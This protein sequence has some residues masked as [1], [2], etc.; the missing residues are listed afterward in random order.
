MSGRWKCC[1]GPCARPGT[2][3]ANTSVDT[4]ARA[5]AAIRAQVS[6]TVPAVSGRAA[7]AQLASQQRHR[8]AS[9]P[10]FPEE[11][12]EVGAAA[13]VGAVIGAVSGAL[14]VLFQP[15]AIGD[16]ER[17]QRRIQET[18]SKVLAPWLT[19]SA[20]ASV[21]SADPDATHS[22]AM[23]AAPRAEESRGSEPA[24]RTDIPV[25]R[26][27]AAVLRRS[28][29]P[30]HQIPTGPCVSVEAHAEADP[31]PDPAPTYAC[32]NW[33]DRRLCD[34][35]NCCQPQA[36]HH[37]HDHDEQHD[38]ARTRR[39]L[40]RAIREPISGSDHIR[41]RH[42]QTECP[43]AMWPVDARKISD[44][45]FDPQLI[46]FA[47]AAARTNSVPSRVAKVMIRRCRCPVRARRR[48]VRSDP[49]AGRP[50]G[51]S[52]A[53]SADGWPWS[54]RP[55]AASVTKIATP[56]QHHHHQGDEQLAIDQ[57]DRAARTPPRSRR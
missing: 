33:S 20:P 10:A 51:S 45:R 57:R 38:A 41:D 6:R 40:A 36:N 32:A 18:T 14:T 5:I 1:C 44:P 28:P 46:T 52:C 24:R 27:G 16:A 26:L 21:A 13:L 17:L 12:D 35:P 11:L 31:D 56:D 42:G 37:G 23:E 2:I 9:A 53:E 25:R 30:N 34:Q 55:R 22:H 19:A 43:T 8:Q 49:A 50:P 47:M 15:G 4:P 7:Y 39:R 3:P 29:E 54:A 48:R